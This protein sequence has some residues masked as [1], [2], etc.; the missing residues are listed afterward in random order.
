MKV[1]D[2]SYSFEELIAAAWEGRVGRLAPARLGARM[3]A[4]GTEET[5]RSEEFEELIAAA[6]EF[7][8]V[9]GC[10]HVECAPEIRLR[11]ALCTFGALEQAASRAVVADMEANQTSKDR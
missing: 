1:A 3:Y 7:L 6:W 10:S 5:M 4:K 2:H 11:A 9:H 8:A